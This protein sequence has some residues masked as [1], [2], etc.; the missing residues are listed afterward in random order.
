MSSTYREVML[1]NAQ[2]VSTSFSEPTPKHWSRNWIRSAGPSWWSGLQ[3]DR[4]F[5]L[6][7]TPE[8]VPRGGARRQLSCSDVASRATR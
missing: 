5:R 8:R 1:N 6:R 3:S 4:R 7:F 2:L